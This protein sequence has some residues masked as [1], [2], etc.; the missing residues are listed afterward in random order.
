[1]HSEG[2]DHDGASDARLFQTAAGR[3]AVSIIATHIMLTPGSCACYHT[4][5]TLHGKQLARKLRVAWRACSYTS[6]LKMLSRGQLRTERG[7]YWIAGASMKSQ[8]YKSSTTSRTASAGCP[9]LSLRLEF[10]PCCVDVR[11]M[12]EKRCTSDAIDVVV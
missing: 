8:E 11:N 1:M 9:R 12:L 7:A 10:V 5:D 4:S 6:R 2:V 3:A